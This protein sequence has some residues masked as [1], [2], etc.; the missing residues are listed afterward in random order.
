MLLL[1]VF[2]DHTHRETIETLWGRKMAKK[3]KKV[4]GKKKTLMVKNRCCCFMYKCN[5]YS[6][7][8]KYGANKPVLLS[9]PSTTEEIHSGGFAVTNCIPDVGR[10]RPESSG[11]TSDTAAA[12][13]QLVDFTLWSR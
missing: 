8:K 1:N 5:S 10:S 12:A 2:I 9:G 6:S 7:L 3:R 4:E 13:V 11:L